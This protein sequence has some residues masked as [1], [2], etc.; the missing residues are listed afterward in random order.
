VCGLVALALGLGRSQ[1]AK[2]SSEARTHV[3]GSL[4]RQGNTYA[5]THTSMHANTYTGMHARTHTHAHT[6]THTHLLHELCDQPEV[7]C[8]Q[9][10]RAQEGEDMGVA[11]A[12]KG[13]HLAEE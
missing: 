1:L 13:L 4:L 10:A 12:R 5:H 6:R 8:I 9:Q 7:L 2:I 11:H 3:Q